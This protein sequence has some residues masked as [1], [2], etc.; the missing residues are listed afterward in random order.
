MNN[1]FY[2][3]LSQ[4]PSTKVVVATCNLNQWALDFDKNLERIARSIL[5]AKEKGAT[6]RTGPE[7]E[8]C[9][10]GCED[11]FLEL[12]T[13]LHS[14]QSLAKLLSSNVTDNILCE[15]GCPI[16][17]NGVRY[18]C[19]VWCLN[20]KILL[21]RP[22]MF[23]A[24]DGNYR[25]RR[26]FT[27]WKRHDGL[28]EFMLS[29]LLALVTGQLTV[30]IGFGVIATR[31]T[32]IASEVCEE[33][34][35][36]NPPHIELFSSGVEIISNGSGSH[37]QLRKLNS[38]LTLIESAGRKCGG[39]YIYSNHRGCD[40]GRLYFDGSSLVSVNGD[41]VAQATQFSLID[42]E[43]VTAVVDLNEVRSYRSAVNSLQEQFSQLNPVTVPVVDARFFSLVSSD[44]RSK[45][46]PATVP[47]KKIPTRADGTLMPVEKPTE[48]VRIH[49]PEEECALGPACWL[50]DY[51]R[52]SGAGGFL[53]PLSGGADSASVATI[54]YVMCTL[55]VD[56]CKNG[57]IYT[58]AQ[59][60]KDVRRLLQ[61]DGG[62][63]REQEDLQDFNTLVG[64][65][66]AESYLAITA[67]PS[68]VDSQGR[69]VISTALVTDEFQVPS[70]E[71]LCK[72]VL[73]TVYMGTKNSSV[74]T[75]TRAR[76]LS[77]SIGA[78]HNSFVFDGI[79]NSVLLVF[80]TM[81]NGRRPRFLSE[82]G[83]NAEDLALQNIQARIRMVMAYLCAQLFPW[84]R[85]RTGFLLVLGSANV[86]ESLRGYMTKYDCS[87][88][89]INPIGGI[90][91][92]DLKKM[93]LWAARKYSIDALERI[94]HAVPTAE[95][96]PIEEGEENDYT[97][98]DEEDMGMT[99][100]ELG[101][102]GVLRKIHR[103]GP[104]SMFMKLLEKWSHLAASEVAV[105]VKRFFYYYSVNRHKLT[106][107]TPSY[108]AENY[109][110]D[111][112]RFD[113]RQFLYNVRWPRQFACIDEL[114]RES[115][116]SHPL[117]SSAL[118]PSAAAASTTDESVVTQA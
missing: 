22:K 116:P 82:G 38:R 21:I 10:Y 27:S 88:A 66:P 35:T 111:D 73:N 5:L 52:R 44:V 25:E 49:I 78:Y 69:A 23:L 59:V 47:L 8:I 89:D 76:E 92:G 2:Q 17:Y 80:D 57:D 20:R 108:H 107:L 32:K 81:T 98:T 83:T 34:W 94:V 74:A 19:R 106:T 51:L 4:V 29:D 65:L 84:V 13:F 30:P 15:I 46:L 36:P 33:L 42:V 63:S 40:G 96:R 87:S 6:F 26:F 75:L 31:E 54:V 1:Q 7:L 55:V 109:G 102:F 70:P 64:L 39:V 86:D 62:Y 16:M 104:V 68:S 95:L 93:M 24:D 77:A 71:E 61:I 112:N 50:W 79:V 45:F 114:V 99:Y 37:H 56:A 11:H 53:L 91:K 9:G 58:R 41:I 3:T 12:D 100:E 85:D 67:G 14:E 113:L 117:L 101:V 18:N 115:G 103:C 72:A 110:T 90:C 28:Q 118:Q 105:K 48:Y 43:V 97:Q 60:K